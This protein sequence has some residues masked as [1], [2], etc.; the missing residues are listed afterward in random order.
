MKKINQKKVKKRTVILASF[1]LF[2]LVVVVLRLVQL[3]VID[4]VRLKRN[5]IE[6]NRLINTISPKRGT[7]FDRQGN[8]LAR[9]IPSVSVYYALDKEEPL[10]VQFKK[11]QKLKS[12]MILEH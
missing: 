2:W 8:I 10:D 6:Q 5:V 4:H 9:S 7:I 11:I 12:T 1:S 3:Q